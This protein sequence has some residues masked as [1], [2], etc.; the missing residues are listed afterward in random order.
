LPSST[1]QI[2]RCEPK[3]AK[4]ERA[5]ATEATLTAAIV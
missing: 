2:R 3:T 5:S 1:N 4:A